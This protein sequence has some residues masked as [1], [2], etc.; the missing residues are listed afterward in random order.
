MSPQR[1]R[2]HQVDGLLPLPG[3]TSR[4]SPAAPMF[5][6]KHE[7]GSEVFGDRN[8]GPGLSSDMACGRALDMGQQERQRRRRHA[9]DAAGLRQGERPAR[10]RV[11]PGAPRPTGW[12]RWRSRNRRNA[13]ALVRAEGD[14]VGL[15][16]VDVGGI[17]GIDLELVRDL[18]AQRWP[19]SGQIGRSRARSISGQAS[20]SKALRRR[21]SLLTSRPWRAASSGV[22]VRLPAGAGRRFS[23][24]VL[25]AKAWPALAPDAAQVEPIGV[26]RWSALSARSAGDIRPA[27]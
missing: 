2:R 22:S 15:L 14:D 11:S 26:R 9:F 5:H 21:P 20:S 3:A 19:I 13:H 23:A 24:W 10:G 12:P 8:V 18:W 25:R 6:V 17:A 16:P 4:R 1:A 27:R 7:G